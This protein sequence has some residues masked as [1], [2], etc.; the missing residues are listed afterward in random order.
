MPI[1]K[2]MQGIQF[3]TPMCSTQ[4]SLS[5]G[6]TQY[7]IAKEAAMRACSLLILALSCLPLAG[8]D[9]DRGITTPNLPQITTG[10]WQGS[11][12]L[13][14]F[15]RDDLPRRRQLSSFSTGVISVVLA[16]DASGEITGAG[17]LR[18]V[19]VS[20]AFEVTGANFFP[21]VSLTFRFG[22]EAL[23]NPSLG[24]ELINFVGQFDQDDDGRIDLVGV[25]N[26]GPLLNAP[27]RLRTP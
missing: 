13:V 19:D 25:L 21:D 22:P 18:Q 11:V 24:T 20:Y 12:P 2:R 9:S 3:A 14:R 16:E 4:P 26:G 27:L 10:D 15:D 7:E 6:G 23:L 1:A 5:A 8:C 17:F